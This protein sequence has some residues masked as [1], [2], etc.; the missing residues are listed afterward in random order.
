M[1]AARCPS[2]SLRLRLSPIGAT[3]GVESICRVLPIAPS[4]HFLHHARQLDATQRSARARRD[5][6]LR[7]DIRRVWDANHQ[8]YGPRKVWRN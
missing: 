4:T 6:E 8:V 1:S 3:Y 2:I 5:D 7:S